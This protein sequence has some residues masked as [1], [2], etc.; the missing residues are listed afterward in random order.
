M[1][2]WRSLPA[3]PGS[4]SLLF[5]ASDG[6]EQKFTGQIRDSETGMD[7]FLARYYASAVGRFT[8]PDAPMI[9][10]DP[11]DPQSWNL[12][13]YVRNRPM[14]ATD[15]TGH[16][17]VDCMW[18]G[19]SPFGASGGEGG[20][21]GAIIDGVEQTIFN[22][23]GLGNNALAACPNNFCNGF[24][25]NLEG[26]TSYIQFTAS[27]GSGP[28]GYRSIPEMGT[29]NYDVGNGQYLNAGQFNQAIQP[30]VNAQRVAFASAVASRTGLDYNTVYSALTAQT[31]ADGTT[32][33]KGGNVQFNVDDQAVI[34]AIQNLL[35]AGANN[36]SAG[37]PSI[38]LHGSDPTG[39]YHLDTMS[40]YPLLGPGL[41]VHF[42]VD[43][44]AGTLF[45]GPIPIP[46]L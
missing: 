33:V 7:F 22:T 38:H 43:V 27:A 20:G 3:R 46:R 23:S 1:G 8:S 12:Y 30:A 2:R 11:E 29:Y 32:M 5:G 24:G 25:R 15:P 42:G 35:A 13:S 14:N 6:V 26:Q 41:L 9:G 37:A 19:C 36:G 28:Q 40:P 34:D 10:S 31:N 44:F 21:G 4:A 45:Y 39:P 17:I 18:D 16:H